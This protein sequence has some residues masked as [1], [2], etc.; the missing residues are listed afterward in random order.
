MLDKTSKSFIDRWSESGDDN[1]YVSLAILVV[2]GIYTHWKQSLPADTVSHV[3]HAWYDPH[4]VV[5]NQRVDQ[6]GKTFLMSRINKATSMHRPQTTGDL[7]RRKQAKSGIFPQKPKSDKDK[8]IDNII[9]DRKKFL[10]RGNGNITGFYSPPDGM[11]SSYQANYKPC[12]STKAVQKTAGKIYT[13]SIM[14]VTPDPALTQKQDVRHKML[15]QDLKDVD[16][17]LTNTESALKRAMN[18]MIN[19]QDTELHHRFDPHLSYKRIS[20]VNG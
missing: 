11:V 2:K 3:K 8:G 12:K 18:R 6:I 15:K 14:T 13:S 1:S 20:R 7:L 17:K 9:E 19:Y 16:K 5:H 4:D 10:L